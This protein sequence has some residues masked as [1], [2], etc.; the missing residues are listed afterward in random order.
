MVAAYAGSEATKMHGV[1]KTKVNPMSYTRLR[2]HIITSTKNR[3]PVITEEVEAIIYPALHLKA[4]DCGGKLL[5]VGGVADHVHVVT[6][7]PPTITLAD[8]V[9]EI[10]TRGSRAVT[11]AGVL[12]GPFR[13]QRGYSAFTLTPLDLSGINKRVSTNM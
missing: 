7:L 4:E 11:K 12:K 10:K 3:S 9:R 1:L 8:F 6:A 2:Y 13:W 5:Q